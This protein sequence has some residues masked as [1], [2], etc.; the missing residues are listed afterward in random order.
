MFRGMRHSKLALLIVQ[1][2]NLYLHQTT[3]WLSQTLSALRTAIHEQEKKI[4]KIKKSAN[5][6][7]NSGKATLFAA[8]SIKL[9]VASRK[10]RSERALQFK[11]YSVHGDVCL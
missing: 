1:R 7:P 5:M 4:K 2:N 6:A 9:P 8:S 11:V 10:P 3:Q